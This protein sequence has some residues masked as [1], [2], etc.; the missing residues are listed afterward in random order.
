MQHAIPVERLGP[1]GEPMARAV[2]KC[3]HC[4]FC[5]P[6]CPTYQVLGEEID[7]PRGR[8]ILMK[9]VL[10]EDLNLEEALPYIDHCLGCL[11]CVT[12]CPSGV[13][14]N[15]LL[16]PFRTQAEHRRDHSNTDK[17]ARWLV[18][19]TLPYPD[20]FRLAA[21]AGRMAKPMRTLLPDQFQAMLSLVP[22]SLPSAPPLPRLYPA[23]GER[24]A[25]VALLAGCVQQVLAPEIDWATLRVL[26]NNGVDVLI[27]DAQGCC[28]ALAM[29]SGDADRA[30]QLAKQ[31]LRAFPRDV[32]AII[33]N[34]AGCGS[35]MHEYP[36]LF[37][38]TLF[39]EEANTFSGMVMD[40]SEFLDSLGMNQPP[41][42]PEP[43]KLAYHDACHLAHAQ[44]ITLQPRRLLDSIPNLELVSISEAELCCG[45]AGT[46]NLEQPLT[47][48]LLGERKARNILASGAQGVVSGNIGCMVQ[49]RT[50]LASLGQ[51]IP[52]WHTIEVLDRAYGNGNLLD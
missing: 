34:A 25:R 38:G 41:P 47:A 12:A 10:E 48:R 36:L 9:S 8:I 18:L 31:N 28:G 50:S 37:K 5:L 20:R 29:H 42:L 46:Y 7:S 16:M 21:L 24:R 4:G 1:Q 26:A 3:V 35:G 40:I 52:V 6:T 14:Y 23:K 2:E 45:S 51:T 44:G 33:T 19:E 11:A 27:P 17:A 13:A 22:D 43:I 32:D 30:M 39:E 15:E 49:L